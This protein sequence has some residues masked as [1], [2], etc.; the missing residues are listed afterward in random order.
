VY[1]TGVPEALEIVRKVNRPNVKIL[2]DFY[3]EQIAEGNLIAKLEKNVDLIGL[4]HI[5]D[6]P[7]RHEPGTGEINYANIFRRLAELGYDRYVA[8]EFFPSKSDPVSSLRTAR[9]QAIRAANNG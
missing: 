8:M 5:A 2:Y 9:T 3:H 4:V 1:L 7:G 6:V